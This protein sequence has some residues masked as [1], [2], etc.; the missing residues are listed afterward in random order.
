MISYKRQKNFFTCFLTCMNQ[1]FFNSLNSFKYPFHKNKEH[2]PRQ[3]VSFAQR[4]TSADIYEKTYTIIPYDIRED[5]HSLEYS[6]KQIKEILDKKDGEGVKDLIKK[7]GRFN[8]ADGLTFKN[9][10]IERDNIS[11]DAGSFKNLGNII[12]ITQKSALG[13]I[14]QGWLIH[15]DRVV[16][17]YNPSNPN[18][19]PNNIEYY[20]L[21]ELQQSGIND[22][23]RNVLA[24]LDPVMLKVRQLA[25]AQKDTHLKIPAATISEEALNSLYKI[26]DLTDKVIKTAD[27]IPHSTLY[28]LNVKF[29]DYKQISGQSSY[30]F[31]NLGNDK[32]QINYS[33]IDSKKLGYLQRLMVY[34]KEGQIKTGYLLSDNK[35]VANFNP[36]IPAMLPEKFYYVDES[37]IQ[38]AHYSQAFE[39]YLNIYSDAINAYLKH[40]TPDNNPA[41]LPQEY[42]PVMES[43]RNCFESIEDKFAKINK[44][45]V[46][47]LKTS[48]PD[49]LNMAG[50]R[51]YTFKNAG[52][53]NETINIMRCKTK[54]CNDI[55]KIT[56]FDGK[57]DIKDYLLVQDNFVISNYNPKYPMDI[58]SAPKFYNSRDIYKLSAFD[59][60]ESLNA[61][62]ADFEKF[63]DEKITKKQQSKEEKRIQPEKVVE[64]KPI[65]QKLGYKGIVAQCKRDFK[66]AVA[67]L[68][69]GKE[70]KEDFFK[71]LDD[72]RAKVEDYFGE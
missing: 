30:T 44:V 5:L 19:L 63:V 36:K 13:K 38:N 43:V 58:P 64:P 56:V 37:K 21:E 10:G 17:N 28:K 23:L 35:I 52:P 31:Q 26:Q 53:N 9:V 54:Q 46:S 1:I 34:D 55:L 69:Q 61:K 67:K 48:Y 16:K 22:K 14:K 4:R 60:L 33:T 72:I 20:S 50:K 62:I 32:I 8:T 41:S 51:G 12:R 70:A 24:N 40:I 45:K 6:F 39:D 68:Q 49:F 65:S 27:E 57:G 2:L 18:S 71:A 66:E 25:V 11:F 7:S 59:Y 42:A 29:P 15:N 3:N 47:K